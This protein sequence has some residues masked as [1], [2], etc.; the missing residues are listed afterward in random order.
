MKRWPIVILLALFAGVGTWLATKRIPETGE[1][2]APEISSAPVASP[3]TA[4]LS[5]EG[6]AS[7]PIPLAPI[8][9]LPGPVLPTPRTPSLAAV[10]DLPALPESSETSL[11][12]APVTALE[13]MR[14]AVRQYGLR[15]GENPVGSNVEITSALNGQN[16]RH[17]VFVQ[18][19][20]G[21]RINEGGELVDSWGTP[22]FFHQLSRT[23]MEIHSAGPDRRMW[24]SD[25]LVIK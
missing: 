22:Y 2:V 1:A 20:D 11:L 21:L 12:P 16:S 7:E 5:A 25:D 15:F 24:T 3:L 9:E 23:E 6:E 18:P 4:A 8:A 17:V 19:D 13:N 10:D 14:T